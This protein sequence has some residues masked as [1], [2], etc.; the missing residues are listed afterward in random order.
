MHPNKKWKDL[1]NETE[2]AI[3]EARDKR[4]AGDKPVLKKYDPSYILDTSPSNQKIEESK[5]SSSSSDADL[6][7]NKRQ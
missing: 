5:D 1:M 7:N 4:G 3:I 2:K 6:F